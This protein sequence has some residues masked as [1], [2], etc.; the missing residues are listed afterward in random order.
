MCGRCLKESDAFM[1]PL[2]PNRDLISKFSHQK[3]PL[4][5][6]FCQFIDN[7]NSYR[8]KGTETSAMHQITDEGENNADDDNDPIVESGE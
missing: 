3:S 5:N 1:R 2:R 6:P 8:N 4:S 7:K